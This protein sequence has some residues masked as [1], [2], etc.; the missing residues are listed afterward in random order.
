MSVKHQDTYFLDAKTALKVALQANEVNTSSE[1]VKGLQ[2]CYY[3]A[4][5]PLKDAPQNCIFVPL[6]NVYNYFVTTKNRFPN[7]VNFD[8]TQFSQDERELLNTSIHQ[9]LYKS[10]VERA[11]LIDILMK[12]VKELKPDFSDKKLRVF[13]PACRETTVIKN[14]SENIAKTFEKMGYDV[15]FFIQDNAMQGCIDILPYIH[16]LH[17][18][19]PHIIVNINHLNNEYLNDEVF[20]FV[21]F[22][23]SM[24]IVVNDEPIHLRKRDYIYALI[25]GIKYA[26]I[27]KGVTD[28]KLQSF[29]I[30]QTIYKKY[31]EVKRKKKVV[32]IGGAYRHNISPYLNAHSD[33][34]ES[35]NEER[36]NEVIEYVLHEY[37]NNGRFDHLFVQNMAKKF[38]INP[39]F[40][41]S[42]VIPLV[43]RDYTL[44]ELVKMNIKYEI[45]IYGWGWEN[46]PKLKPYFKGV[47]SYGEEISKIYNSA[48]YAIIAHPHYLIQQRTLESAASGCIPVVYD[49]RYSHIVK[50][51]YY[52]ESLVF[53][54]NLQELND[55]LNE[56]RVLTDL[57]SLVQDHSYEEFINSIISNVENELQ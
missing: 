43:I 33:K 45:E 48:E 10:R 18:F 2:V 54:K 29:C 21:W 52:E 41:H 30:D 37:K 27:N 16:T 7:E 51:P 3:E 36:I 5:Q 24:P 53:F 44:L 14:I 17:E 4:E 50:E 32:F 11:E 22:Q 49:C 42:Y 55:I 20:N 12:Q 38:L 13:V 35:F 57:N 1:N 26:L 19:N 40:I 47:L 34:N 28:C 25:P 23:D 15:C 31:K 8:N 39:K 56:E 6:D 9:I 46:Y